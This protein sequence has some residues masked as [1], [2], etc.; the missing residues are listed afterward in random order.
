[1]SVNIL[2]IGS[3]DDDGTGDRFRWAFRKLNQGAAVV[4]KTDDVPA[5]PVGYNF[6]IVPAAATGAWA[7]QDDN[8]AWYDPDA[9]AWEFYT[10]YEG[11]RVW[12]QDTQEMVVFK[13][14][15]WDNSAIGGGGLSDA[16][17]DGLTYGRKD[18]AWVEV[19]AGGGGGTGV[20]IYPFQP[21]KHLLPNPPGSAL[22]PTT[23]YG[24]PDITDSATMT[25]FSGATAD[26]AVQ[27]GGVTDFKSVTAYMKAQT[28]AAFADGGL[29]IFDSA[30]NAISWGIGGSAAAA[31][32]LRLLEWN[33]SGVFQNVTIA[34]IDIDS[35]SAWLHVVLTSEGSLEFYWSQDGVAWTFATRVTLA[36]VLPSADV[37]DIGVRV[38]TPE[39]IEIHFWR[40]SDDDFSFTGGVTPTIVLGSKTA[41][42]DVTDTHLGGGQYLDVGDALDINVTIPLGLTGTEPVT[43]ER[44]GVGAVT[45]VAAAGVTINSSGALLA[46][47]NQFGSVTLVPKG[48]DT[49]VLIGD[50]A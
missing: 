39:I 10:P 16:P 13:S 27:K 6:Y 49:Y 21:E 9:T 46:I 11:C 24:T 44:S 41:D 26:F 40:D 14:T 32:E 20:D 12:V 23:G 33:S 42:F 17:S 8:L 47:G 34:A 48:S 28:L 43:L 31:P 36:S 38:G 18:A 19:T 15:V 7:G 4:S 29:C 50:L 30:G 1:M 5:V 37:N 45:L 2:N 3:A 35:D 22:F 25:T